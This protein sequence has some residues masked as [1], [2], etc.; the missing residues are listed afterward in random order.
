MTQKIDLAK[1]AQNNGKFSV[2]VESELETKARIDRENQA[3][4]AK[5]L[6]S[7]VDLV[8]LSVT[9]AICLWF[10]IFDLSDPQRVTWCRTAFLAILSYLIGRQV[11]KG[12]SAG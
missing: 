11:G 5:L 7:N 6:R 10:G 8:L 1:V 3:A 9:A 2:S 4:K 12:E